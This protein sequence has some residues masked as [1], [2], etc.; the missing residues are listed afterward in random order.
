MRTLDWAELGWHNPPVSAVQ[1]PGGLQ[2][3]TGEKTDFWRRTSYGFIHDDGHLLAAPMPSEAAIEVTFEAAYQAPFDQAGLM[4]RADEET[5]LKTGVE[6]SD[7]RLWASVVVTA[8]TSDWS[9]APLP[10]DLA[11]S[12]LVFRASRRGDAVTVRYR[13]E[14]SR[15]WQLL[16]VA[17]LSPDAVV[18]AGPMCCSPSRAGLSVRFESVR[19]GPPEEQLHQD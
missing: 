12:A 19:L 18:E 1:G 4:L 11:R 14:A 16:R 7:G 8:G 17:H 9:L 3:V 13:G 6:L 10:D 5:W 2:V 15:D